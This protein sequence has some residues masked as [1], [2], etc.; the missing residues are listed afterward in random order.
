MTSND[1][2]TAGVKDVAA[3]AGVSL[4]TVSNV[5]NR[6]DR[7]SAGTRTRVERAMAELGFVRNESARQLRAGRSRTLAY[8]LLDATNPFFTDVAQGVE[9]AAEG[10]DLSVFTCNSNNS[11]RREASYLSRLEQMRVHGV[12]ITPVDPDHPLLHQLAR[13]GTP[14]VIVDRT[15]TLDTL[16]AVAVDDVLGGALAARHLLELG[17]ERLAF[18]G[19][20]D[21]LGQVA[22][23]RRGVLQA[24]SEAGLPAGRM[25]E[26]ATSALTVAEGAAPLSGWPASLRTTDPQR[27]SAPTTC[28]PSACSSSASAWACPCRATWPSSATTTSS[29]PPPPRSPSPRCVSLAGSSASPRPSC[30][31][32]RPATPPRALA[33]ALR[34]RA[35][36]P[37]LHREGGQG[38]LDPALSA[39]PSPLVP[40]PST[41]VRWP[42]GPDR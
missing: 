34:P 2:R 35:D 39:R 11:A 29:S 23:R 13:R 9:D 14:V 30:C 32:T 38:P 20:P 18:V 33:G 28:W 21:T 25:T 41:A 19:G 5:L 42:P 37:G 17:H 4:G 6:P 15:G 16:C 27:P 7:V 3:A 1:R 36:R 24:L 22:D 31:S 26:I 10:A 12:L 40:C 8:V